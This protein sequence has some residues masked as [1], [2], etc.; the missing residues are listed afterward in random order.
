MIVRAA[1]HP[2]RRAL[3]FSLIELVVAIVLIAI[4]LTFMANMFFSN[5]G[6]SVEP[7][8]QIRAAEFGQGL[9]EEIQAKPFDQATPIGG[10]PA[11]AGANCTASSALGADGAETRSDYNDV[12]DYHSYCLDDGSGAPGWPVVNA[13][14][15][16]PQDFARFRMRVCVGY[17][18]DYDGN[19]NEVGEVDGAKLIRIDIYPPQV[20]GL[21]SPITFSAYR[22]NY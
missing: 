20:G 18:D 10:I 1:F 6:R 21:G 14:G 11:C 13:P 12:D 16:A 2:V 8:L 4:A 3:G 17:D 22:G 7:L 15:F 19:I 9:M 5:P